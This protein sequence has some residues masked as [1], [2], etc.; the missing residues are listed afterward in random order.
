MWC[1]AGARGFLAGLTP[2]LLTI[3]PGN[4]L[5][6]VTYEKLKERMR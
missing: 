1:A 6:W 2:R 5:A 4:A 3:V